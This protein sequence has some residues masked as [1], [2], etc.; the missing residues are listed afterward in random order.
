M[1]TAEC[2]Q[3]DFRSKMNPNWMDDKL[4]I[5]GANSDWLKDEIYIH[6][7]KDEIRAISTVAG[8]PIHLSRLLG[9]DYNNCFRE[10]LSGRAPIPLAKL[11]RMLTF[12]DS[13]TQADIKSRIEAKEHKISCIYSPHKILFPSKITDNLA[14][15][16]GLILGDGT[17][18]GNSLNQKGNW[19][20]SIVFDDIEHRK[21]FDEITFQLFGVLPKNR[22]DKR[23][24]AY[25]STLHSKPLHWI[26]RSFFNMHNGFK[27][28]KISIPKAILESKNQ[29]LKVAILQGLFDSDGTITKAGHVQFG[30]AS[31]IIVE[32]M[33]QILNELEVTH[34]LAT[35]IKNEKAL[36]L[37]S[38][39]IRRKSSV[40]RFAQQIGF[41]HPRKAVLLAKFSPVVQ[42]SSIPP[43]GGGDRS[44]NLR[45]AIA[46][47]PEF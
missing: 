29:K 33:S 10:W 14:Y 22:K 39:R 19:T 26:L 6:N 35:W 9:V 3:N 32:Q 42:W 47:T 38:I 11:E 36:P 37:H 46:I 24:N 17:L 41:R 27:A 5:F 25:Y 12:C 7:L 34:S 18:A 20:V 44:S 2:F 15:F 13:E 16:I 40:I 30:S 1:T 8:G 4:S 28:N 21:V 45:R 43:S 31:K 23:K